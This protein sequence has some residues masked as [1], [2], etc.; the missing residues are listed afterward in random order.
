[1]NRLIVV[2]IAEF[3]TESYDNLKKI[4]ELINFDALRQPSL[5]ANMLVTYHLDKKASNDYSGIGTNASTFP[6]NWC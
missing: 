5:S 2:G 4:K 3:V 6:C 1:M